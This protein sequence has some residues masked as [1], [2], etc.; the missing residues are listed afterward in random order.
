MNTILHIYVCTFFVST[1]LFSAVFV[2]VD[3]FL[4]KCTCLKFLSGI[5]LCKLTSTEGFVFIAVGLFTAPW[6]G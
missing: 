2:S 1:Y 6:H 3:K 4:C 5:R